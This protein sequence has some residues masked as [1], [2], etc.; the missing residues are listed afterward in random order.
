VEK[1]EARSGFHFSIPQAFKQPGLRCR[2]PVTQRRVRP[3]GVVV[4]S[5]PLS[6]HPD[7]FYRVEDFT[8]QEL[9]LSFELKLSQYP[10]SHGLPGA[11]GCRRHQC[12]KPSEART[13]HTSNEYRRPWALTRHDQY[14]PSRTPI[15]PD[16]IGALC[17]SCVHDCELEAP[18]DGRSEARLP[19]CLCSI[20]K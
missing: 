10:F 4:N 16:I 5:R 3:Y 11:T 17:A 13:S 9:V 8:V 2:W 20:G 12:R 7:V 1:W 15:K 18:V 14:P 19:L 6:Q